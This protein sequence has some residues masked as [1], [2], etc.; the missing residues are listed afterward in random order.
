[1]NS[2]DPTN[3][4]FAAYRAM[5]LY[6][7]TVLFGGALGHCILNFSRRA[8]SLGFFA[9][10]RWTDGKRTTHEISLNPA[11]LTRESAKDSASTLVH[12]MAHLHRHEQPNPPRGGYHD[13]EWADKMV[14]I[15]LMPSATAAP[16]G[17]RTGYKM[18]HYVIAG[19]AFELAFDAMP[20]ECQLPWT[21]GVDEDA[22]E[23]KKGKLGTTLPG[24]GRLGDKANVPL[25]AHGCPACPHPAIGP[26]I[27]GS[28][29]VNV[30]R[31]PALRVDDP[32]IHSA[33]C[34]ANTWNATEGSLTV[35][36]NGKAA[37]RMGDKNR[38]CGGMGKLVE[39]SPNVIVG[40]SGG[41]GSGG[42]SGGGGGEGPAHAAL[43]ADFRRARR[44]LRGNRRTRRY[45]PAFTQRAAPSLRSRPLHAVGLKLRR[46]TR[47]GERPKWKAIDYHEL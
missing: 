43:G 36:I 9:P 47:R 20:V 12:E 16:G 3:A 7:N 25:D 42:S 19:G 8:R 44:V 23:G 34:G 24:Q 41:G 38:H 27:Q 4:Q 28:P 5:W 40:E 46:R 11:Y 45:A 33:C 22:L 21:C 10:E 32:G 6:F 2:T 13:T 31:R 35:F 30:N 39:G 17:A 26:A 37:H 15:G 14:S 29:D 18:S 1:M